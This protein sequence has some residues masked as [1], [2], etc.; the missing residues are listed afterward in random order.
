MQDQ[1]R[2]PFREHHFRWQWRLKS[3]PEALWPFVSDSNRTDYD[4]HLPSVHRLPGPRPGLPRANNVRFYRLGV[5][6]EWE[7]EPFEWVRS[8]RFGVVRRYSRGPLAEM[9]VLIE[10]APAS[11]GGTHLVYEVWVRPK[12]LLGLLAIPIQIGLLSRRAFEVAFPKYDSAASLPKPSPFALVT[13][14]NFPPGG[15]ERLAALRYELIDN[16]A[17][18]D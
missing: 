18:P 7:E 14:V 9:R 8:H 12:N 16:G 3:S 5:P 17:N 11:D 15:R 6:L 2:M 1:K 10:L 13:K 4:T